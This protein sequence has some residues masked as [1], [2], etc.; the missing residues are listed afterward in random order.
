MRRNILSIMMAM[1]LAMGVASC[2]LERDHNGDLAGY[3]HLERIDTLQTGG[4]KD[5]SRDRVFWAVQG[6][7]LMV[8]NTVEPYT[9]FFFRF[10]NSGEYL[11]LSNP[12]SNGGHQTDGAEGD[13]PITDVKYLAPYGINSWKNISIMTSLPVRGLPFRPTS[14]GYTSKNYNGYTIGDT[15][16]NESIA[17]VVYRVRGLYSALLIL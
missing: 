3:W 17:Y 11:I 14:C 5:M 16:T 2:E 1:A 13:Q 10:D 8:R 9:G 15:S 12:H 6:K 4:V 7:L